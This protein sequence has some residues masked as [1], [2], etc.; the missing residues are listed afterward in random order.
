[1]T[2]SRRARRRHIVR[3][4]IGRARFGEVFQT[5]VSAGRLALAQAMDE[6]APNSKLEHLIGWNFVSSIGSYMLVW[7]FFGSVAAAG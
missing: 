4:V 6:L 2:S 1:M 5:R 3:C 7:D